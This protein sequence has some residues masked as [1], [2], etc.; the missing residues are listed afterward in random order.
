M[1]SNLQ[2]KIERTR[3]DI[4]RINYTSFLFSDISRSTSLKSL[5]STIESVQ[6]LNYYYDVIMDN[7]NENFRIIV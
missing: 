4:Q 7:T 1:N 3:R 2:V 6:R 5:L